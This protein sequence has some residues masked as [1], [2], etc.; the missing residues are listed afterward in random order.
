MAERGQIELQQ[1]FQDFCLRAEVMTLSPKT[2]SGIFFRCIPGESMNG[3]E[4]QVNNS[5]IEDR[6]RPADSG[7]GAIF[8]RQAARAV[9]AD[10]NQW[11]HVTLVADGPHISSWVEGI[12]VVDWTDTRKPDENPRVG[13]RLEGGSIILQAHDPDC[14][15]KFRKL[16]TMTFPVSAN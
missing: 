9:L 4:C 1:S 7:T 10:D 13:L 8:R 16:A 3:Y 11:A 12:Q 5:F 2:N 14:K 15:A 6:R